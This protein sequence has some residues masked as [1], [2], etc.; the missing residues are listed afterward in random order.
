M[1]GNPPDALKNDESAIREI[2]DF[3]RRVLDRFGPRLAGTPASRQAAEYI[4]GQ[5]GRFC[6]EVAVEPFAIHPASMWSL[7]KIIAGAYVLAGGGMLL[8]GAWMIGGL[9]VYLAA[10]VFCLDQFVLLNSHFDVFF[11]ARTG[12]NVRGIIPP[13]DEV[14]QQIILMGHHDSPPVAAFL[15]RWQKWYGIRLILAMVFFTAG[16]L[17]NLALAGGWWWRGTA[18]A[19]SASLGIFILLGALFVAPLFFMFKPE[20]SP[21]AGDNLLAVALGLALGELFSR[22]DRRLRHTRLVILSTDAEEAGQRGSRYFARQHCQE[23][24]AVKTLVLNF[25]AIYQ[26]EDLKLVGR[27]TNGI[28]PLSKPMTEDLRRVAGSLGHALPIANVPLGGGGTD[29]GQFAACGIAAA[30]IIGI[31]TRVFR[32]GLVYHTAQDTVDRLDPKAITA[33][34]QIAKQY[35]EEQDR[36]LSCPPSGQQSKASNAVN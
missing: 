4:G 5:L 8:G 21:G 17:V 33:C 15:T 29:A 36:G 19:V 3:V 11:P 12:V 6:R 14:K 28:R 2:L 22:E 23:L 20:G 13:A 27:D 1:N 34:W 16:L 30:S 18:P 25:D 10:A 24:S 26:Y 35:I 32:E 7:G 9:L 31:S